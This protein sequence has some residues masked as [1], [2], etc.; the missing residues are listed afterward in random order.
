M[1]KKQ[2]IV[3]IIISVL[4]GWLFNIFAGRFLI[5]KVSTWP[6]LNRW[7][8]LS[9]QAPI[10][11]NNRETVR[12][13]DSGDIAA[14][15]SD[16]KS[17]ISSVA[18]VSGAA[19][20]FSGTAVNLTSDGIFVTASGSFKSKSPGTYY[21]VLSDGTFGKISQQ[22]SD[23]ATS[24]VFFK[25][26]LGGVPVANLAASGDIK[27]GEKV[28]FAENSLQKFYVKAEAASISRAQNDV[29][30]QIFQSDFPGRA[31]AVHPNT[32]L[33][34]GEAVVNTNGNIAGIWNGSAIISS[35]VLKQAM[36][37]YFNNALNIVRPSFGFSYSIITQSDSKLISLPE[38]AMV[39]EV[40]VNSPARL[41]GLEASDIITALGGQ[42]V[43]EGSQFE[44]ILEQYK[45]GDRLALTVTR[46]NQT[47]NLSLTV[48]ELK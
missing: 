44:Q 4:A 20:T 24:L 33:A 43:S 7:K 23:P 14:A 12:V 38:G 13:S 6:F 19:V 39:K 28:L 32:A 17:K 35:D 5:A 26:E 22:T 40:D 27:V 2:A 1:S 18:Q 48:G 21:V 15:A 31:F 16:V 29:E 10:V 42:T 11:I 34:P 41:A 8:I 3:I 30:G 9:P 25:A 37:L 36:A 46:K 45:P 47:V